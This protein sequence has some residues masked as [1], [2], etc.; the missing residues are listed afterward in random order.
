M[1]PT[2]AAAIAALL[3]PFPAAAQWRPLVDYGQPSFNSFEQTYQRN[4]QL[5]DAD[6]QLRNSQQ[7]GFYQTRYQCGSSFYQCR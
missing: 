3:L 6:R 4:Q 2:I 7:Q 1:K 5:M